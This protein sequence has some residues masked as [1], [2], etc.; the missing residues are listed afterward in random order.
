MATQVNYKK[1]L[2][3]L[4]EH[5]KN[6]VKEYYALLRSP[7]IPDDAANDRMDAIWKEAE[8]ESILCKYLELIDDLCIDSLEEATEEDTNYLA[9]LSEHLIPQLQ[10]ELDRKNGISPDDEIILSLR[11]YQ[12][13]ELSIWAVKCPDASHIINLPL[14]SDNEQFKKQK[15]NYCELPYSDHHWELIHS[16]TAHK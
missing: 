1:L 8:T 13:Q 7:S 10:T 15:C 16:F 3:S 14:T 9:Y 5:Q 11:K 2:R 6:L 4:N 12:K